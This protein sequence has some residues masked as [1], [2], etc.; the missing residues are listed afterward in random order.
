M[1][2][3][4][5]LVGKTFSLPL[6]QTHGHK[7]GQKAISISLYSDQLNIPSVQENLLRKIPS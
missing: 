7:A 4:E 1:A 6:S 3:I 2:Q 5:S